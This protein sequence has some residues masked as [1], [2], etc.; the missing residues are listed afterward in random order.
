MFIRKGTYVRGSMNIGRSGKSIVWIVL[1]PPE[2]ACVVSRSVQV[3]PRGVCKYKRSCQLLK[4]L[5]KYDIGGA[6][7]CPMTGAKL[8]S[9]DWTIDSFS[10]WIAHNIGHYAHRLLPNEV[11]MLKFRAADVSAKYREKH[12][13]H[14]LVHVFWGLREQNLDAFC[15]F[16]VGT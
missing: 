4:T 8:P 12:R 5:Q 3:L 15:P 6:H 9:R 2:S 13:N 7:W 14:G 10:A 11:E 1:L 16:F